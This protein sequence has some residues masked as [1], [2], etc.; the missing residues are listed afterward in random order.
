MYKIRIHHAK[1]KFMKRKKDDLKS[2]ITSRQG[3]GNHQ[4]QNKKDMVNHFLFL[5]ELRGKRTAI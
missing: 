2:I 5:A 3:E 4:K 1:L